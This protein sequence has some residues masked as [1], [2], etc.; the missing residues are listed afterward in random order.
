LEN[1]RGLGGVVLIETW[2]EKKNWGKVKEKL[3]KGYRWKMQGTRRKN[4]KGRAIGGMIM[5]VKKEL[6]KQGEGEEMKEEE[7]L[8]MERRSKDSSG[9]RE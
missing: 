5:G 9:I 7:E 4:K 6:A 1:I 2:I 8:S 3:P